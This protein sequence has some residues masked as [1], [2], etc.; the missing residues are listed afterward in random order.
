ML[1]VSNHSADKARVVREFGTMPTL[2]RHSGERSMRICG[3]RMRPNE[4]M[5]R[6][7]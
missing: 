2:H 1:F 6:L 3:L 4:P 7:Q 5:N